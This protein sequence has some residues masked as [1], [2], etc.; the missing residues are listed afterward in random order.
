MGKTNQVGNKLGKPELWL[1]GGGNLWNE[2]P[3]RVQLLILR[4]HQ[5]RQYRGVLLKSWCSKTDKNH[6]TAWMYAWIWPKTGC[7]WDK[8]QECLSESP[9]RGLMNLGI[10]TPSWLVGWL[11]GTTE[12][13]TMVEHTGTDNAV[14]HKSWFFHSTENL[15][16]L[17]FAQFRAHFTSRPFHPE[18]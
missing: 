13:P 10:P 6:H 17:H 7:I 14:G 16:V 12:A 3:N 9:E 2:S 4:G 1:S 8:D 18:N 15:P 11:V 5:Q